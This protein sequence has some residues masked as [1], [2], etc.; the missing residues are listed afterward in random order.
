MYSTPRIVPLSEC[1]LTVEFGDGIT[2]RTNELV[3][4]GSA[5]IEQA[6]LAGMVELVPTYRSVTVYFDP[7]RTDAATLSREIQ[8]IITRRINAPS[9]PHTTHLIPVWYGGAAGPDLLD[10]AQQANLTQAEASRLHAS[11]TYRVYMLGFSPGFPY[12]GTVPERIAAPRLPTPRRHVAAGS[13]GI[14]G[15]QT[16]IY[17]QTSPGGWRI[18][19]RTPVHLFRLSRPKPFLLDP[20]DVVRFV[21]IDEDEFHRL[22]DEQP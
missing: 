1:A 9:R 17:P 22:F 10:L 6:A 12:L 19:G 20:G 11:V 5:S 16:G 15:T 13:V 7:L 14:A 3:L 18:I 4:A 2:L 21:P 8:A